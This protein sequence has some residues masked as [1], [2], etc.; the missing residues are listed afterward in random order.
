MG[1]I[2]DKTVQVHEQCACGYNSVYQTSYPI[3]W[4]DMPQRGI[5]RKK[6]RYTGGMFLLQHVVYTECHDSDHGRDYGWDDDDDV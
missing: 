6:D 5:R 2:T 3:K 1:K 4:K